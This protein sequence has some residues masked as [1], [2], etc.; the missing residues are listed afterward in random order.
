MSKEVEEREMKSEQPD[1]MEE[2][3]DPAALEM[4]MVRIRNGDA[5][6][7]EL[8]SLQSL[9]AATIDDTKRREKEEDLD[10]CRR[11]IE[12]HGFAYTDFPGIRDSRRELGWC[13]MCKVTKGTG[14]A[15]NFPRSQ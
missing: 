14:T 4:V 6:Y 8:E 15:H 7:D 5:S 3:F 2:E 12:L 10:W 11:K 9:I 13:P 1:Q